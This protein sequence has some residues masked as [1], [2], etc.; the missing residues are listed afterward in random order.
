[1]GAEGLER[2]ASASLMRTEQLAKALTAISGVRR[3]FSRP[4]FHETVLALD[5]PVAPVLAALAKRDIQG[6]LDLSAYYPELGHA[7]L[8]C[9]TETKNEADIEAYAAALSEVLRS[10]RAA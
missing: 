6:G 8:V 9:A 1:M 2:V 7:L 5:R 3:M 4:V 10:V